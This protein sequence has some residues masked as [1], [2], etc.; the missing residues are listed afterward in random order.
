MI[1]P[2]NERKGRFWR[3]CSVSAIV[4]LPGVLKSP[5]F[6]IWPLGVD[7]MSDDIRDYVDSVLIGDFSDEQRTEIAHLISEFLSDRPQINQNAYRL[8]ALKFLHV[9]VM[10]DAAMSSTGNPKREWAAIALGIGLPSACY[11]NLTQAELA[12]I[13][14]VSRNSINKRV[15][16]FL[17]SVDLQSA[18]TTGQHPVLKPYVNNRQSGKP[19]GRA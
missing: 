17:Q 7:F 1:W 10:I 12:R 11:S 8:A 14:H 16:K 2:A 3:V 15:L 18:F 4:P 9:L 6:A 13:Y 5:A 19:I